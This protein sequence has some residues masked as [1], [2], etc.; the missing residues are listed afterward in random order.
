VYVGV[1]VF[2]VLINVDETIN[3]Q[4]FEA[5]YTVE[6]KIPALA[7]TQAVSNSEGTVKLC[8]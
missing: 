3:G 5:F 4:R 8:F 1:C 2:V 6:G 7:A